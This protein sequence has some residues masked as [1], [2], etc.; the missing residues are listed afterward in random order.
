MNPTGLRIQCPACGLDTIVT[1]EV[2][3][4]ENR[5]PPKINKRVNGEFVCPNHAD[6]D[7]FMAPVASVDT[8]PKPQTGITQAMTLEQVAAKVVSLQAEAAELKA[9]YDEAH[10]EAKDAKKRYENKAEQVLA[11]VERMGRHMRGDV[12]ADP[13]YKPLLDPANQVDEHPDAENGLDVLHEQLRGRLAALDIPVP[14]ETIRAW[15]TEEYD[16]VVHYVSA[17]EDAANDPTGAAVADIPER[18]ACLPGAVE[19]ARHLPRRGRRRGPN[20]VQVQPADGPNSVQGDG[21]EHGEASAEMST[22]ASVDA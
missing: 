17:R 18:P 14:L 3:Q 8:T 21:S 15:S 1:E 16:A 19:P 4:D 10:E 9:E 7:I 5:L 20:S 11:A 2:G 22:A 13:D 6:E 12:I